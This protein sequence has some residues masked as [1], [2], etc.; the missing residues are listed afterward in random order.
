MREI[1]F[2]VRAKCRIEY[3]NRQPETIV[4]TQIISLEDL[5]SH[6]IY[7]FFDNCIEILTIDE[8]TGLKDNY[9]NEIYENDVIKKTYHTG[10]IE[11]TK[12][13]FLD[14]CFVIKAITNYKIP[15]T[16]LLN[17]NG[18]YCIIEIIGNTHD[19]PELLEDK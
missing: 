12:V 2:R 16:N 11:N 10:H 9:I 14:G 18:D 4:R 15:I 7:R 17:T 5:K 6:W 13:S 3:G 19:N 8:Y 1:K